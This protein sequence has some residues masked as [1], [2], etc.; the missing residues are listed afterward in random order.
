[1]SL[2]IASVMWQTLGHAGAILWKIV[3]A[4]VNDH[5]F[6]WVIGQIGLNEVALEW[7]LGSHFELQL[8]YDYDDDDST[9]GDHR[10]ERW[11][12]NLVSS[13]G[14]TIGC[15]PRESWKLSPLSPLSP[16]SPNDS[17]R[18]TTDVLWLCS[19]P[20]NMNTARQLLRPTSR[21]R[22]RRVESSKRLS[23]YP[24]TGYEQ[25]QRQRQR[26]QVASQ[27]K[28]KPITD[29]TPA[30][31]WTVTKI[32]EHNGQFKVSCDLSTCAMYSGSSEACW[33]VSPQAFELLNQ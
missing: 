14:Q 6:G 31:W 25:Q 30:L 24:A 18:L 1:M 32:Q 33:Q 13:S 9:G 27:T 21:C 29:Q 26:Q 23:G 19:E 16:F 20:Q 7:R 12:R 8:C 4:S 3:H 22:R 10:R 5:K 28:A 11:N 15:E 2:S 17:N